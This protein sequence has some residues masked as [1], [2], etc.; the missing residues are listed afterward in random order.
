MI[1]P[2]TRRLARLCALTAPLLEVPATRT[3]VEALGA[4]LAEPRIRIAVGGRIKAG[5]STMVNAL[6]GQRLAATGVGETTTL[7]AWFHHGPQDRVRV[8]RRDGTAQIVPAAPGGGVPAHVEDPAGVAHLEVETPNEALASRHTVVDTPGLNSLS[9]LDAGSLAALADADGVI[10]LMPHPGENDLAALEAVRSSAGGLRLGAANMI[11]VLSRIDTLSGDGDPWP[12]A[13]RVAERYGHELRSVLSAVVPVVGLMAETG[14]G[15]EFAEADHAAVRALAAADRLDV[16]DALLSVQDFL[17]WPDTPVPEAHRRRLLQLLGLHG[18]SV[19]VELVR[20][21]TRTT[22]DLLT[23]LTV[24][25][26]IGAVLAHV[27]GVFVAG[28]DRLRASAAIA[29][30]EELVWRDTEYSTAADR[31]TLVRLRAEL[32]RIRLEP[33][34][35]QV[36]LASGLA[37]VARGLLRL[38]EPDLRALTALATGRDDATRLELPPDADP[39]RVRETADVRI[40]RWRTLEG[41]PSRPLQRYARA[42]RELTEHV[43]FAAAHPPSGRF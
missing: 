23:G 25:S 3:T 5:K 16:E 21:G 24:R 40:R 35:R 19:A 39:R 11:G 37:D 33:A 34:M 12:A 28:A 13:H 27:D 43:Y 10:Y 6:L 7:V 42:A 26:G 22:A 15:A 38:D 18:T 8:H 32:D 17:D 4:R 36:E 30:L 41:R 9:D 1:G 2:L 31:P 20:G 14:L 29:A